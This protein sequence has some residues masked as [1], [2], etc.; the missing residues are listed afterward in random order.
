MINTINIDKIYSETYSFLNI[1]GKE[2]ID[3]IPIDIYN[4]IKNERDINYNPIIKMNKSFEENA[5]TKETLA[6]IAALNLKYWCEN[7]E[8]KSKLK[9]EYVSNSMLERKKV[10][11]IFKNKKESKNKIIKEEKTDMVKYKKNP[12][13]LIIKRFRN[14][15]DTIIKK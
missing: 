10:N 9:N 7:N 1:L 11:D 8:E 13:S 4:K 12:I 15:I 14:I 3:K 6:L 5:M 2:Y